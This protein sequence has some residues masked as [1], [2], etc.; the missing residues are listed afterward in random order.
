MSAPM[1]SESDGIPMTPEWAEARC[2]IP[3][4]TIRRLAI[5]FATTRP[6]ALQCEGRGGLRQPDPRSRHPQVHDAVGQDRD[7][8]HGDG[9]QARSLWPGRNAADPDLVRAGRVGR[10]VSVDAVQP[11]VA[12]E[13][14]FDPRQPAA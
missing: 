3:A 5:E 13:D 9:G 8:L 10:E 4:E 11:E 6:A 12:G 2:G 1:A 7:L 14:A